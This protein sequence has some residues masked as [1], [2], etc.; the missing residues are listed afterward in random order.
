MAFDANF[1]K[2]CG[3]IKSEKDKVLAELQSAKE[4]R[5]LL[6]FKKE[7]IEK[8]FQHKTL[9][10]YLEKAIKSFDKKSDLEKKALIQN[11]IPEIIIHP[12]NKI[13]LRVNPDPGGKA[14]WG[15]NSPCHSSEHKVVLIEKWRSRPS[16][17]AC[18]SFQTCQ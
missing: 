16:A 18:H 8:A 11:V 4:K 9:K 12:D 17:T 3:D 1:A 2:V 13:E 5:E 14:N 7:R 15:E 10:D 6:L